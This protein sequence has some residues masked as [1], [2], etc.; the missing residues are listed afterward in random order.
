MLDGRQTL[1]AI[2][3]LARE[4][5][6][7]PQALLTRFGIERLLYRLSLWEQQ[8]E[9]RTPGRRESF[10]LKGAWCFLAW[11][12]DLHR[13]TQ[14]VDLRRVGDCSPD[15]LVLLF[16]EVAAI[17]GS[18]AVRFEPSSVSATPIRATAQYGGVRLTLS[19]RLAGATRLVVKIDVV[20]GDVVWP[21][22]TRRER[23]TTLLPPLP[24]PRL[25]V[26]SR[27]SF[28]AEKLHAIA[29]LGMLNS[30]LKDYRD[31]YHLAR[32]AR[33]FYGEHLAD[34]VARTF[35]RRDSARP[36][37]E[38]AALTGLSDGYAERPPGRWVFEPPLATVVV[39]LRRLFGP[40]LAAAAS[41]VKLA[42]HW[43]PET[44]W[45]EMR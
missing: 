31:L 5:G 41:G 11:G 2:R 39:E 27:E 40:V 8:M 45:R 38:V 7:T 33:G 23:V 43:R 25:Y 44:G 15:G 9:F 1:V 42:A 37:A 13:P 6:S 17:D 14:D 24:E 19:G 21:E 3:R 30:R 32:D 29:S 34:A 36:P 16:R 26:Y 10:T 4:R 35:A 28:V 12:D 20:P 22:P 18:D